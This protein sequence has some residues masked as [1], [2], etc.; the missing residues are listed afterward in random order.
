VNVGDYIYA[1]SVA[2]DGSVYFLRSSKTRQHQL[3]RARYVNGAYQKA[4][5]LAFSNPTTND[6]DP[7][8][9]PDQS[10]VVFASSGR[11]GT[12]KKLHLYV[13]VARG[14][15]W[16]VQ[17][18]PFAGDTGNDSSPMLSRDGTTLYFTSDRNG[19]SNVWMIPFKP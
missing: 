6:Y 1:P 5:P 14:E 13:A 18:L 17:P 11:A 12:D 3:F 10:Y 15:S 9:G 7:V 19:N 16:D 8:A 4:E 2:S